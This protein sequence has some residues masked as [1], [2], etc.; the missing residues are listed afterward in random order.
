MK[1]RCILC[2]KWQE[3]GYPSFEECWYS[4]DDFSLL[5]GVF[6]AVMLI[7]LMVLVFFV[8]LFVWG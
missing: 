2:K 1:D 5:K 3:L 6:W 7:T 8:L 4:T